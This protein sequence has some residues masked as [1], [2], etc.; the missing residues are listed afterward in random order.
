MVQATTSQ[1]RPACRRLLRLAPLLALGLALAPAA[2]AQQPPAPTVTVAKPVVKDVVEYDDFIGRFEAVDQVDIRA[3]VSGYVDK[4]AFADGAIVKAGDPLFTIDQRPYQAALEE[5]QASLESAKA[6]LDFTTGDLA[7]AEDLRKTGN[8]SGQIYDQR[9]Q[10]LAT[11]RADVNRTQATLNR[12]KLDMQFTEI[13]APISGRLSR[14][15]VSIGNLVNAND[16]IL[17]N[18]VSMDPIQFYFDV[19]ER[20]FL[21]YEKLATGSLKVSIGGDPNEVSVA[22]SDEDEPTHKGHMD[23]TENRLD[24]ASGTIRA[25]AEFPNKDLKLVPGLFGRIRILGS[26]KYRGV[27][28]PEEALSTDQDRRVVYVV[29]PDNTVS[30]QPVRVGSR[31]DGYRVIREGLKG[32]ETIVVNGLMRVRPGVKITPKPTTLPDVYVVAK[33]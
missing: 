29:G 16:T 25:R 11:A 6:N 33:Q 12:A 31:V 14:R 3:R 20:S 26:D 1:R 9:T 19:D 7:R 10:A 21:A 18:I 23:F 4:I 22:T 24:Q 2:Q 8:I 30:L 5:A 17:T 28:V 27:L 32:D 15:L 13:K